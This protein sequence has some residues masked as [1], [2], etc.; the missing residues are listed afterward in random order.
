MLAAIARLSKSS[1]AFKCGRTGRVRW[2]FRKRD[3][4][5]GLM[6]WIKEMNPIRSGQSKRGPDQ[7]LGRGEV[8]RL[9]S[10]DLR[11]SGSKLG[12]FLLLL[13]L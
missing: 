8:R 3:G 7:G 5:C 2:Q 12:S 6:G 11:G 4:F 1:I 13:K 10:R 9:K